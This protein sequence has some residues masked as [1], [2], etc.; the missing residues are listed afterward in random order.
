[1]KILIKS[2]RVVDPANKLDEKLDLL[3]VDG[4]VAELSANIDA[5]AAFDGK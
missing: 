5:G 4:K 2:G 1:M 3:I